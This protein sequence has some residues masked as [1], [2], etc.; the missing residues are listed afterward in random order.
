M[1]ETCLFSFICFI[2]IH[3]YVYLN[4]RFLYILYA[5]SKQQKIN[6]GYFLFEAKQKAKK[7]RKDIA[8]K[9]KFQK[10]KQVNK[11]ID[12]KEIIEISSSDDFTITEDSSNK[13]KTCYFLF[14]VHAIPARQN[15]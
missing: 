10:L 5:F 11:S 15:K 7:A 9:R 1:L 6:S 3:I 2:Y 12:K 4:I 14:E 13:K 8:G